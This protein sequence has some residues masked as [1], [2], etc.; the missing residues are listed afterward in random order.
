LNIP[1][2]HV[3]GRTVDPVVAVGNPCGKAVTIAVAIEGAQVRI[4]VVGIG[5][6]S[7]HDDGATAIVRI[8]EIRIVT[9][10]PEEIAVP[11]EIGISEAHAQSIGKAITIHG[12]SIAESHAIIGTDRCRRVVIG[13]VCVVVVEVR[14][15]GLILRFQTYIIITGSRAVIIPLVA[16]GTGAVV[17]TVF[18]AICCCNDVP[19]GTGRVIYI[20]RCLC[21]LPGRGTTAEQDKTYGQ[22]RKYVSHGESILVFFGMKL[23]SCAT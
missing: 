17:S 23:L 6:I 9:G 2:I 10:V 4:H 18:I 22:V 3:A 20:I 1:G 13:I 12:V 8:V 7:F 21:S 5:A 14:P 19:G 15:A 16:V 11:S